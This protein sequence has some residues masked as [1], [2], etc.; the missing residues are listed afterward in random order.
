[1]TCMKFILVSPKNRTAYNFRGDLIKEII[2]NGYEVIVTGPNRDNVEKIEALGA[3]FAEIPMNKNGVNP[4]KDLAYQRALKTLFD[5]EKPDAVLGY[6]SKPVIYGSIA[7][8]RAGVKKITAMITGLGYAFTQKTLKARIIRL[9]MIMLY[10]PALKCAHT[11][12]FQNPDDRDEVIRLKLVKPEKCRVVNGSGV[13]MERFKPLPYPETMTFF[14]LA[15]VMY[16]KGIREYLRAA[17]IVKEKYPDVQFM[18]LGACEGIQDSISRKDLQ[19]YIDDGTITYFGETDDVAPYY[20]KCSVFVLP[21]YR[22]GT[23]R[24][25][26]EAMAT[27][28]P[29]IATDVAGCRE[30]VRN[31]VTGFLVPAK[32]SEALAEKM[33]WFIEHPEKIPEM[34][35][36]SLAYCEEKYDVRKVNANMLDFCQIEHKH[37]D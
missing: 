14:M 4:V 27:K 33:I 25:I 19:K 10:K 28:R 20:G 35:E 13:N 16:A 12:V 29:I 26:L 22:E 23:G 15:R 34:G 18:L 8:K 37:Q 11:V 5:K 31:G 32:D 6:T 36:A 9:I 30:T 24:V 21:S 1:M 17:E 2:A 3:R 7:A